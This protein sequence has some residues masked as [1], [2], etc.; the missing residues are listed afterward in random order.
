MIVSIQFL[1]CDCCS[2]Q[3]IALDFEGTWV[4]FLFVSPMLSLAGG[5][6]VHISDPEFAKQVLVTNSSNYYRQRSLVKMLPALGNGVLTANGKEH[7]NM[8][9][10]LNPLFTHGSVRQFISVFN[11][12][13]KQLVQVLASFLITTVCRCIIWCNSYSFKGCSFIVSIRGVLHHRHL[14]KGHG[15]HD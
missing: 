6:T 11:D 4:A 7:A 10:H 12:K 3:S 5:T 9:K 8:R 14:M 1:F 15:L 13:A 2:Q